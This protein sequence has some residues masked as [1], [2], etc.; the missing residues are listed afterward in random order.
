MFSI[1]AL[2]FSGMLPTRSGSL[3]TRK[4]LRNLLDRDEWASKLVFVFGPFLIS[5]HLHLIPLPCPAFLS[6]YLYLLIF[7]L[8]HTQPYFLQ[9]P[10]IIESCC[11]LNTYFWRDTL[12]LLDQNRARTNFSCSTLQYVAV[13]FPFAACR[14]N[15]LFSIPP[16]PVHQNPIFHRTVRLK[17]MS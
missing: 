6:S 7:L 2:C 15:P 9:I 11:A 4:E 13:I 14:V 1:L 10:F 16:N 12:K 3:T 5:E 8:D 17:K